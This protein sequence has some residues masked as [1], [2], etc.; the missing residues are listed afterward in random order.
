MVS[1]TITI[2]AARR[3]NSQRESTLAAPAASAN[4][5]QPDFCIARRRENNRGFRGRNERESE[6]V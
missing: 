3:E 4:V 6:E 1:V 5:H 2:V